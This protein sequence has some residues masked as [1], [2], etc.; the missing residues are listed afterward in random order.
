VILAVTIEGDLH[1]LA[2]GAALARRSHQE[3]FILECDRMWDR[4]CLRCMDDGDATI[5]NLSDGQTIRLENVHVVWW[6]RVRAD[7]KVEAEFQADQLRLI[8]NDCRGGLA[9]ALAS[10][11]TGR[12]VSRPD[13]T[14]RAADKLFQLSAARAAGF[15]TPRTLLGQAR[16]D[17]IA[18]RAGLEGRMIVKPVVGTGGALLF[19]QFLDDPATVPAESFAVAPAIYQEYVPGTR[20]IR[21]NCF[22]DQSWAAVIESCR[23]DWRPDLNV[24]VEPWP[25]PAG[26]HR[27]V[28]EVLDHLGLRMGIVDLKERPDGE[29]VWLEVNPQGQFL[30]LDGLT[31]MNLADRF[32]EFLLLEAGAL[33]LE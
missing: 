25:V 24:P 16:E 21:L 8:N 29:L 6:R 7:Q 33:P 11:I 13:A 15:R 20:H 1:A 9:G 30:F 5:R 32:A 28:R 23:L 17:V 4:Y 3:Y 27:Q 26:V 14:D 2:I 31:G 18:F 19:T 22:G 10:H 12:W